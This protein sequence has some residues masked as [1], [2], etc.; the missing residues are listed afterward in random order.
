MTLRAGQLQAR[1]TVTSQQLVDRPDGGQ[2]VVDVVVV[3]GAG[4]QVEPIATQERLQAGVQFASATH[5]A[6]LPMPYDADQHVIAVTP[7]MKASVKHGYTGVVTAYEIIAA[8]DVEGR[9][10]ELELVLQERV[11]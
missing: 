10:R 2:D 5:R 8:Q 7:A 9:G 6:R 11:T 3:N 1:L 4:A